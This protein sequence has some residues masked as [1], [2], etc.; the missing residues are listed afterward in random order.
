MDRTKKLLRF[1][2]VIFS[3][4][5]FVVHTEKTT[6]ATSI[7]LIEYDIVYTVTTTENIT[8]LS[9]V[10]TVTNNETGT[11]IPL[12]AAAIYD[13]G[14]MV[15]IETA[16]PTIASGATINDTVSVVIPSG[17]TDDYYIKLFAWESSGS[18]R[19]LG[20]YKMVNDI[21]PYLREKLTYVTAAENTEFKLF[22]NASTVKGSNEDV[23]HTIEYDV[24]KVQPI[25]LC[26]FTNEQEM[27]AATIT[28][29]N[30]TIKSV[31]IINGKIKYKF[32]N[33]SGRNTG[34]NNVIEFKALT[35]ITDA[36]IKYTIQ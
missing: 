14:R 11:E 28:N 25:D 8:T 24:S 10:F 30:I 20:K 4:V 7:D 1:I 35:S 3:L 36:E 17:N 16:Q 13:A 5:F 12:L 33:G 31:D 6:T 19:P 9:A 34:I 23:V 21:D 15:K 27:T 22:M 18:L 26:G 32:L 2:S 29:T